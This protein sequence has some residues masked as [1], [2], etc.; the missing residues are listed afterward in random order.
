MELSGED[1]RKINDIVNQLENVRDKKWGLLSSLKGG[2]I[3]VH[4]L[5]ESKE[6]SNLFAQER[7]LENKFMDI[8]RKYCG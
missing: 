3:S 6:L 1:V 4:S 5:E 8:Q 2:A 7:E